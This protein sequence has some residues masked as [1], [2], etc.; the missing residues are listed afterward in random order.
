MELLWAPWR[1]D[2]ILSSHKE[3]KCIFCPLEDQSDEKRLILYRNSLSLVILN[4]YPY[5]YG[6]LMV[7]P[8]R[9]VRDMSKLEPTEMADIFHKLGQSINILKEVCH[10]N[11]FNVGMNLG[12][13]A[14]AGILHHL[15]FHIVPRW[16]G[17]NNFMPTVADIRIIPEHLTNTYHRFRPHF[18]RLENQAKKP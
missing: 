13:V 9:H 16:R 3:R 15:H 10:P 2:Y 11:G 6:H 18:E 12:R 1:M 4:R 7:A 17:D 5:S 14:G 8:A